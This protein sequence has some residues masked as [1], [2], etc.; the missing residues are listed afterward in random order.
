MK[1]VYLLVYY[2]QQSIL[3]CISIC[4]LFAQVK[5]YSP[6][7]AP[8]SQPRQYFELTKRKIFWGRYR[9]LEGGI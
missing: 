9:V 5:L 6:A 3:K 8:G 4:P 7:G 2:G 1:S